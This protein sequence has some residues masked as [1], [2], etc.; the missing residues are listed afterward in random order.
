MIQLERMDTW[1][2]AGAVLLVC[3]VVGGVGGIAVAFLNRW[4]ARRVAQ[5]HRQRA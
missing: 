3:G 1:Y 5:K 4:S 2:H